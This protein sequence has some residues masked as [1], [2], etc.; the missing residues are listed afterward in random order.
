M[1]YLVL[2]IFFLAVA[3]WGCGAEET[4]GFPDATDMEIGEGYEGFD[5]EVPTDAPHEGD[6]ADCGGADL[7][8]DPNNCGSCGFACSMP[9]ATPLCRG[10]I[11]QI[12]ECDDGFFDVDGDPYN[13]CEYAC[14]REANH[15][16]DDDGTCDDGFD[17]DCDGR[18]DDE[19]PD[20]NNCVP[21]F[22]N[23]RDDD[24][25]SLIDE[26]YDLRS[27]PV[28]C[29]ACGVFC[30]DRPN[31]DPICILGECSIEC[32]PG[33]ANLDGHLEN[34]TGSTTTAT[35]G[36]TRTTHPTRAGKEIAWPNPSAWAITRSACL[37]SL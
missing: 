13:G 33:W 11:C 7:Q 22:C 26:D 16:L 23:T 21:E 4:R 19:D 37:T 29:G 36:L 27:D 9:H 30:P 8:N 20:C 6:G 34:A 1:K 5:G 32:S 25:D 35:A 24:C 15:E 14:T 28:N 12:G 18:V 2:W 31:A 17:N 3:G 10:G